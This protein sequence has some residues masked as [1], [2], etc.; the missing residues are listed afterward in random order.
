MLHNECHSNKTKHID[1]RYNLLREQIKDNVIKIVYCP[2]QDMRSDILTKA[3]AP[4]PF[5]H[6]RTLLLGLKLNM[7]LVFFKHFLGLNSV[8]FKGGVRDMSL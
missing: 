6:L 5:L 4:K 7:C 8:G 2:T 1:I 3:L